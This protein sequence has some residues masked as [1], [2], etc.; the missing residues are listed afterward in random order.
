MAFLGAPT[1]ELDHRYGLVSWLSLG[2]SVVVVPAGGSVSIAATVQNRPSLAP[3]GHYA[4]IL[5]TA[6]TDSAATKPLSAQVG[7]KAVLSSLILLTKSGGA[8]PQL[9]LVSE[10][11]PHSG[12]EL[13]TRLTQRFQNVG[14]VHAVPRGVVEVRGPTGRLVKRGV[15]N[16]DSA[17]VLPDSFRQLPVTLDTVAHAWLPGR[18]IITT[19]YHYD[20]TSDSHTF[21]SSVWYAGQAAV[22]ASFTVFGLVLLG[23]GWWVWRQRRH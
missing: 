3:G 11:G 17:I 13:P 7:L 1:S 9:K 6:I 18:Y 23:G 4:A 20:G 5:A 16:E 19:T 15:L 2:Q 10:A 12:A 22:I 21:Q 8:A 14:N